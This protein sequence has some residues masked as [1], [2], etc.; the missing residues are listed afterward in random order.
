M[1]AGGE[2]REQGPVAAKP[3]AK[4]AASGKCRP[5]ARSYT[6]KGCFASRG[7]EQVASEASCQKDGQ[8]RR[9]QSPKKPA[10]V[11]LPGAGKVASKAIQKVA[12][13]AAKA[14]MPA[15]KVVATVAP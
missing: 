3:V 14:V 1:A 7:E 11:A 4:A 5:H 6:L 12:L 8:D 13:K 15:P 10:K 9:R 2:G